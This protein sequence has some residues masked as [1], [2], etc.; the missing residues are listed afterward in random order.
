MKTDLKP[1]IELD[2]PSLVLPI[3]ISGSGKSTFVSRHFQKSEILSSDF[4]R[5][6]ISDDEGDQSVTKDAFELLHATLVK[7]VFHKKTTVVDA[8]NVQ[9]YARRKS[10]ELAT[11]YRYNKVA[12]VFDFPVDVCLERMEN[13]N[14]KVPKDVLEKQYRNLQESLEHLDDEGFD[15]IYVFNELNDIDKVVMIKTHNP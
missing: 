10:L 3:G 1:L 9:R 5:Y 14:R 8:T 7:R 15:N 2:Y 13:R 11:V 6:M 12:F 4:F